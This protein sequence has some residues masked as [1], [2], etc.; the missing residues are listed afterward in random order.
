MYCMYQGFKLHVCI[1]MYLKILMYC[2]VFFK[3]LINFHICNI[4]KLFYSC[5][6]KI[7]QL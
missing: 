4:L 5:S 3:I 7:Y 1:V 2:H 6:V